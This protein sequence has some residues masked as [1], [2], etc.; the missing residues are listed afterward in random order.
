MELRK[1][2]LFHDRYLL[3]A[4]LGSGASAEVW[5]A[6]D[7]KA[8]NL[9]VALKI[10][11]EHSEFDTYG[12]QN[13]KHEF[14]TVYNMK[15]SNLLPPTGYDVCEGRP[16][17]I[18]QYCE[19]GSCSS[20]AGRMEEED[21]IKF[22]HDVAAGLEYL[23]DHNI[24]HLDIKPDNI[25]LDD[26]CNFLVTDFGIS[27]SGNSDISDSNGMSGGT[28]AYM[29]PER[30]E[31]KTVNASDIWSL[32]ATAVELLTGT[33]PYGEHG[34]LLQAEG[35]PLPELPKL[36]PEV[37]GMI[38]KCLELDPNKRIRANEIRQKI[39][40][41]WET[42]SWIKHSRKQ[43]IAILITAAVCVLMCAGIFLW[44]YTR[45]KVYY[46]KD[47]CE[48]WGVPEGIGRLSRDEVQHR[49]RSYRF[50]YQKGQ[51]RR[52]TLV[53]SKGKVAN[54]TDTELIASRFSDVS[55]SYT[56][57]GNLDNMFIYDSNGKMLFKLDFDE[58]LQ[59]ATFRQNDKNGTEM[60]LNANV[61]DLYKQNSGVWEEKSHISRYLL[62]YDK[63]GLLVER[64]YAAFQNVP[65]CDRD[66]IYGQRYKYDEKG[67]KIEETFVGADGS[68]T[69][70]KNGL[71]IKVYT[72]DEN[73]DWTSVTYLD[74]ERNA[75]HDGN[76]CPLV[77]LEYDEYG[78]RIKESYYT[79]DGVPSIRTDV[80]V[81][82]FTYE[83]DQQGLRV[84]QSCFGVDG[85][86]AYCTFGYVTVENSYNEDGYL[87]KE[88]Y[89]DEDGNPTLYNDGT[90]SYCSVSSK[91][92]ETGLPLEICY[93]DENGNPTELSMGAARITCTYDEAGNMTSQCFYNKEN[94]PAAVDGFYF[95]KRMEYDEFNRQT[96]EY[97]LNAEGKLTTSDGV[98]ADYRMEY[99][100]QG[101]LTKLS[102][103][104]EYGHL[105]NG[106]DF[107]AGYVIEYDERGNQKKMK[108]FNSDGKACMTRSG[109]SS[110]LYR[111]DD[112][113]NF[114]IESEYCDLDGDVLNSYHYAYDAKGNIVKEYGIED[115]RLQSGMTV[116]NRSFDSNNRIV[117]EWST[118]LE[119]QRTNFVKQTYSQ[120]KYVYDE[121]GNV[122]ETS[123]WGIDGS[124]AVDEL[125]AH[126]RD[127]E[128]DALNRVIVEKN[129]GADGKPISGA[130]VY[131]EGRVKY[132][133]WGNMV[134][135]SCYDGYGNPQIGAD[136][137]FIMKAE[138]NK[139]RNLLHQEY[140]DVD[141]KLVMHKSNGF[142]KVDFAY[143]NHGNKLEEKYY[144][145]SKC[146]RIESW[147][148][149]SKN[150]FTERMICDG[151]GKLS[152][153]FYGVSKITVKYD[154][155]G[156]TPIIMNYYN[157]NEK[158]IATQKWDAENGKWGDMNFMENSSVSYSDWQQSVQQV[159]GECPYK[160][161]DGVYA[162][163][164]TYTASAVTLTMKLTEVSKY[165]MAELSEDKIKEVGKEMKVELR[166]NLNLPNGV[167]VKIIITDKA[168][169]TI[170]VL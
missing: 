95:E 76:N 168:D 69:S 170:L 162:Q 125:K 15:Q 118:N 88:M 154:D 145:T 136:G 151:D 114:L 63:D 133:Q 84:K 104:D 57:N 111:Y 161:A 116:I 48:H 4:S 41:F 108:Y 68:V 62:T 146:I 25:L 11:S 12:L 9:T 121:R 53:N 13:F 21:V 132:D 163:S 14:T 74:A 135:I 3:V 64:R 54:H 147:K 112:K 30:F 96:R 6:K 90:D 52:L 39:E 164:I 120:I 128:F 55:Y 5:K 127:R 44:D 167:A 165:N 27:V 35:E 105:V 107:F 103:M 99:N 66:R 160:L 40:L 149:N 67:R 58:N 49:E 91:P 126:R 92:N 46:Y 47:Y 28:R 70:N 23:H 94:Q 34:G 166:K 7:T 77:K 119:G 72:Y 59:T 102:F 56:E 156:I 134:E 155:A 139:R 130:N 152:D 22:L 131:P 17:L 86:V 51:L 143:D 110:I 123:Y 141:G 115:G 85:N 31:G 140:L 144:D 50:E 80:N 26:N 18:M 113:T 124:P 137:F 10:F 75:S 106:N 16:Y 142:A 36:Q 43:T 153:A 2:Y 138:Y 83:Y 158:L 87:V 82:G 61:N 38:M 45:T 98:A 32:G 71:A 129:Y 65:A 81:S 150:K 169:R 33:P 157:Q 24:I 79:L 122:K 60:N 148:Y 101:A 97:Y 1:G 159:A 100:L 93:A 29:A 117:S 42:G 19:N 89:L 78:N 8:N 37:K 109:Y 73:D 20:M